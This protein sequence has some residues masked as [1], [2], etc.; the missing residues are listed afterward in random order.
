MLKM[1]IP[2]KKRKCYVEAVKK[3]ITTFIVEYFL[4]KNVSEKKRRACGWNIVEEGKV[5]K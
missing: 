5:K 4:R 2:C 3:E 1:A